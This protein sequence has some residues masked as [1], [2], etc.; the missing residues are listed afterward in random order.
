MQQPEH[1][2]VRYDGACDDAIRTQLGEGLRAQHDLMEPLP[3]RLLDL[4][5]RLETRI[6]VRETRE[7]KLY[8]EFD[9]CVAAL[10]GAANRKPREPGER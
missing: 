8:A 4:L 7:A 10:V 2:A 6:Y 5:A 1:R 3:P 9:E